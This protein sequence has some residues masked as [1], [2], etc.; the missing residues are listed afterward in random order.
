[1]GFLHLVTIVFS[2]PNPVS[3]LFN[4]ESLSHSFFITIVGTLG[5]MFSLIIISY[6]QS[7]LQICIVLSF[8]ISSGL[9]FSIV[10]L[11]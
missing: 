5:T 8:T 10:T 4:I 2:A 3:I 1:M 7:P 9:G 11:L 6:L